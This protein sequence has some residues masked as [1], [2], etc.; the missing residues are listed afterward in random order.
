MD[1][2][3]QTSRRRSRTLWLLVAA[4]IVGVATWIYLGEVD[5]VAQ[6]LRQR[7]LNDSLHAR[8][9]ALVASADSVMRRGDRITDDGTRVGEDYI[10]AAALLDSAR[11]CASSAVPSLPSPV[12]AAVADSL[13]VR[14]HAA[15][16][17]LARQVELM[18]G[19]SSA[20]APLVERIARIDSILVK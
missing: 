19:I 18:E 10:R 11:S 7:E 16:A 13:R 2:L 9:T 12:S 3:P 20:E 4:L 17:V 15:R 1:N 14:L 8:A 5:N 6:K